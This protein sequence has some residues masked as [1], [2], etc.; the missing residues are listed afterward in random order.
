MVGRWSMM[1]DGRLAGAS[2]QSTYID[3]RGL[4]TAATR[5]D[6]TPLDSVTTCNKL[7][8]YAST[9]NLSGIH[10]FPIPENC[11]EAAFEQEYKR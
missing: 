10:G 5:L 4:C 7:A 1:V 6:S 2:R 9:L 3:W 8:R 11:P